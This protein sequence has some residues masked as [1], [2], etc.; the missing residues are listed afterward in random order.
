MAFL[1]A[2]LD[3]TVSY[4][5]EGGPEYRTGET[6]LSNGLQIR[7]SE[8]IY[9]RHRYSASFENIEEESRDY[10]IEVFHACRGKRHAFK[11]KDYN[12][13]EV[14]DQPLIVEQGTTNPVQ[15]YKI[16]QPSGWP[17]Y[18]VRPIQA[19]LWAAVQTE[20]GEEIPG[21]VDT[22]TGMFY[23]D[24]AWPTTPLVWSGEFYVWV[25][26]T[27]DY[28]AITINSWRNHTANVELEE[29]KREITATNLPLSWEE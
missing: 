19:V 13:F 20:A 21:T 12:D 9:P 7:D 14:D 11:F 24:A 27:D 4:G 23:P 16:Y 1:N 6:N 25:H 15:L 22:E 3:E 18:T 17:A 29:D 5:F 10:L 26:F 28:N 2:I 8:W